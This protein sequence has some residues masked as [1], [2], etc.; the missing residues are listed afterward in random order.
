VL[1]ERAR[2]LT[3]ALAPLLA[4]LAPLRANLVRRRVEQVP[5]PRRGV[6]L[7]RGLLGDRGGLRIG[8]EVLASR[9]QR[10]EE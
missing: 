10:G 8:R 5:A 2:A 6:G 4:P 1:R 7:V 3:Q 9:R